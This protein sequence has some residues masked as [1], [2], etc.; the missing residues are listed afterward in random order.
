MKKF[1]YWDSCE[2]DWAYFSSKAQTIEEALETFQCE[3]AGACM[4]PEDFT[5]D[6]DHQANRAWA[7]DL[8]EENF[9]WAE[10]ISE[11]E[12]QARIDHLADEWE[13]S[14]DDLAYLM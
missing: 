12:A 3:T 4:G 14:P 7:I 9:R 13:I 8:L 1:Q 11:A 2:N 10:E 5:D 6:D